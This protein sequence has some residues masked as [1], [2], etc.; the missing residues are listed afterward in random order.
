MTKANTPHFVER[1]T[2]RDRREENDSCASLPIDLYHRKRRKTP[3]RRAADRTL[4]EDKI[5]FYASHGVATE[6]H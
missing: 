3:D 1:R 2:G 5:Q 6:V 4:A